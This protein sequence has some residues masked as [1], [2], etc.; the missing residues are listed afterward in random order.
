MGKVW[1]PLSLGE[2]LSN[3]RDVE[4]RR[5]N[6][7]LKGMSEIRLDIRAVL[8][9]E[10]E[11][12]IAHCL[13]LD[14]PAEGKTQREAIEALMELTETHIEQAMA[15]GALESIFRPAPQELWRMYSLASRDRRAPKLKK[16]IH[17]LDVRELELVG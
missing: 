5:R 10:D 6:S 2:G 14:L 11:W 9:R 13:E 8:Y 12:W 1:L 15:E 3:R 4:R 7:Q 17:R 16:P